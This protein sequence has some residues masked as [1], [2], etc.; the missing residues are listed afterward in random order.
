VCEEIKTI[1]GLVTEQVNGSVRIV[2]PG[3][4]YGV[5]KIILIALMQKNNG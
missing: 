5:V 2:E 1:I 4:P 3:L